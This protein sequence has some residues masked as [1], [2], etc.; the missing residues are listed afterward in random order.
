MKHHNGRRRVNKLDGGKK[1]AKRQYHKSLREDKP[2]VIMIADVHDRQSNRP[3]IPEG[4]EVVMVG[5]LGID[6]RVDSTGDA[7]DPE[8]VV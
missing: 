7:V 2:K 8:G 6:G 1:R 4:C 5:D 3:E